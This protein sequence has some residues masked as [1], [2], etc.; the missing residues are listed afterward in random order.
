MF[1][2]ATQIVT[3]WK[4]NVTYLFNI[5]LYFAIFAI[6]VLYRQSVY[7]A[8]C[9]D[10]RIRPTWMLMHIMWSCCVLHFQTLVQTTC[11]MLAQNKLCTQISLEFWTELV[12]CVQVLRRT[13]YRLWPTRRHR[14]LEYRTT[15]AAQTRTRNAQNKQTCFAIHATAQ[16]QFR[17]KIDTIKRRPTDECSLERGYVLGAAVRI[18]YCVYVACDPL[19]DRP[20]SFDVMV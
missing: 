10:F 8:I 19:F 16:H 13:L 20:A 1:R 9:I 5:L 7:R 17:T 14:T 6:Q 2:I 3:V 12:W 15:N 11:N 4:P 18:V